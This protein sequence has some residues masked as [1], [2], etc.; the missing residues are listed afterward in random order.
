MARAQDASCPPSCP[1]ILPWQWTEESV[2]SHVLSSSS[3]RLANIHL[4]G[5]LKAGADTL[6]SQD[7]A[8]N[9]ASADLGLI[10]LAVM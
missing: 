4:G 9:A 7:N 6:K 10:G 8:N 3:A 1:P 2:P 5:A